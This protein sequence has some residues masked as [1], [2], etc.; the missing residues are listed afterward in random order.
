MILKSLEIQGFKS[1]PDKTKLSFGGGITAVVGPNGSGKSNISDA[2]RWVL[3]EQSTKTLRGS[4]MEDVIFGGTKLRKP[5]GFAQVALT[6]DNTDHSLPVES[7]EVT[8]TRKLYRSGESEYRINGNSVRLKD[9]YEMF[10][11]TG[12]GK[13]GYSIIGQGRI[14]E[15][16]GAKSAE[17]REI[18]EEASG[19]SK[20]RYRK[21]EAERRLEQAQENLLRL[22]DILTE[23]EDRVG[24]LKVQSEKAQAFLKLSEEKKQLEVSLYIKQLDKAKEALRE[25]ENRIMVCKASYD[26]VD[27]E[28]TALEEAINAIFAQAQQC[29]VAIEGKRTERQAIDEELSKRESEIAVLRNDI[30]HKN[31]TISRIQRDIDTQSLAVSD[32]DAQIS[33]RLAQLEAKNALIGELETTC[34]EREETLNIFLTDNARHNDQLESVTRELAVI[35]Q[36]LAQSRVTELTSASSLEELAQR[37]ETLSHGLAAKQTDSERLRAELAE[38]QG[39]VDELD[40]KI[41]SESNTVKGYEFEL[42]KRKAKLEESAKQLNTLDLAIKEKRQNARLLEDLERSMEGFTQS[43]KTVMKLSGGGALR[44]VLGP[45][46]SLIQVPQRYTVAVET[47]LSFALQNIVVENE[48]VAKRAIAILKSE[49]A[50]RATFLPVSTIEG[51]VLDDHALSSHPGFVGVASKLIA[52]DTKYTGIVNSLLGRIVF[53]EDLDNAVAMAKKNAYRFKIV[54]LD[55]QVV[56]AGGSLT[57]GSTVKSSGLLSR[58]NDIER[59]HE[60]AKELE[61][62]L[63]TVT[64]EHDALKAEIAGVEAEFLATRSVLETMQEDKAKA[65]IERQLAQRNLQENEK[66]I[67]EITAELTR[68]E[69]RTQKLTQELQAAKAELA[70]KAARAAELEEQLSTTSQLKDELRQK[71]R[72]LTD[73]ISALKMQILGETKEAEGLKQ[74]AAELAERKLSQ[75]GRFEELNAEI[76]A[77][78]GEISDINAKIEEILLSKEEVNAKAAAIEAEIHALSEQ[79]L[80]FEKQA[81]EKRGEEKAILSRREDISKEMARLEERKVTAQTDYDQII[82]KLWDEYEL[83]K[84]EASA[85]AGEIPS[86]TNAQRTLSEI[87]GKIKAL[88]TVNV[89]AIEEYKE[90]SQRYEFLKAQVADVESSRDELLRLINE[91]TFKMREIFTESFAQINKNF[92]EVFVELFGGGSAHLDLTDEGDVLESG[93]EIFVEPPGKIIKSLTSLSGGEQAFVAIAIYFAILKVRPAPFCLLDEIEAALDDVNVSKYA[94]YLHRLNDKTQFI[95]ITHRRGTMEEADVLYGVTMQEE[96]VSKLLELKVSEVESKLGL[97]NT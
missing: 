3:G 86:V 12:L 46:S 38:L 42:S 68:S 61:Q 72:E 56:N 88:G 95:T 25:Q 77:L 62:K 84:S 15:I 36:Q 5:V 71:R 70:A 47:A 67:E 90:V 74:S 50:G 52:F 20:Y 23:L 58:R 28:L 75:S 66:N 53:C 11:D 49:N 7:E 57:G 87:K 55:G 22:K 4:R 17:R 1:F 30:F 76:T 81:N 60:Q 14:A 65:E 32:I 19:I 27:D 91:L 16:V 51:N 39:F 97:K 2:V 54:T 48:E 59:L 24:P 43:V 9:V 10:M 79:R 80:A 83:T 45:V 18:F 69:E 37:R 41:E 64:T 34:A 40:G 63:A 85:I 73:E 96:G 92:G 44:G 93:I 31:E 21:T 6:I 94:Q 35:N 89:D 82:A 26:G 78:S 29:A 13:D 33:A 8:V